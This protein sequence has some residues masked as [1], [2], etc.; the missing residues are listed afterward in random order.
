[1]RR[2]AAYVVVTLIAVMAACTRPGSPEVAI[3][4][5]PSP[6]LNVSSSLIPTSDIRFVLRDTYRVGDRV[7]VRIENVGDAIYLYQFRYQA[8]FLSYTNAKG[9]GFMIP[10]GTHC[11]MLGWA[12]IK[13][14]ETEKLFTWALDECVRDVWGCVKSRPLKPGT[15]S[16]RGTFRPRAG[17]PPARAEATVEIVFPAD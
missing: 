2:S 6:T 5:A 16:I 3:P 12:P 11:D 13:P 9:H 14:G 10:P 1:M 4:S 7:A 15:Y 8:C 17:G